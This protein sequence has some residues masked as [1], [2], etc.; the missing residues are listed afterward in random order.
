ML[1]LMNRKQCATLG[2]LPAA[3][4]QLEKDIRS[5]EARSPNRFREEFKMPLLI[6]LVPKA[7]EK[8]IEMKFQMGQ[9]DYSKLA[10]D[11]TTFSNDARIREQR[12]QQDMDVDLLQ[13]ENGPW[14]EDEWYAYFHPEPDED[15]SYM[16]K[17]GW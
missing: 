1:H 14:T 3:V 11:L 8:D 17:G 15:V 6:Q 9:R 2:E 13:R 7:Y 12:G 4:D 16:G 10:S 5:Y